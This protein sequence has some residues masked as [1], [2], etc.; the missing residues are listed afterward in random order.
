ME[1]IELKIVNNFSYTGNKAWNFW[2]EILEKDLKSHF[3]EIFEIISKKTYEVHKNEVWV[4][5][6]ALIWTHRTYPT[7]VSYCQFINH[8]LSHI[9]NN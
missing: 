9:T 4:V 1:E 2:M 5:E 8:H 7:Y 3:K 6:L